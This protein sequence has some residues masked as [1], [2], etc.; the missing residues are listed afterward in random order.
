MSNRSLLEFNHDYAHDIADDPEGFVRALGRYLACADMETSSALERYGVRRVSIRHHSEKFY[1]E[2]RAR[3]ASCSRCAREP[4][5]ARDEEPPLIGRR[6]RTLLFILQTILVGLVWGRLLGDYLTKGGSGWSAILASA[7]HCPERHHLLF[8]RTAIPL[9]VLRRMP[10]NIMRRLGIGSDPPR[11]HG[12]S[13]VASAMVLT[14]YG[15]PMITIFYEALNPHD[16]AIGLLM[17]K[18]GFH[19]VGG[20]FD[21]KRLHVEYSLLA[22]HVEP[23][24]VDVCRANAQER[25]WV[26]SD[27]HMDTLFGI[28]EGSVR[29]PLRP[30]LG[31]GP[32]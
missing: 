28:L 7:L 4:G 14:S 21:G 20:G 24:D 8:R 19:D 32:G 9:S 15:E 3:T 2:K 13:R 31:R 23:E 17:G 11:L 16:A 22:Q 6:K 1:I 12:L 26:Q 18:H 10:P 25:E 27:E 5:P 29:S 30:R